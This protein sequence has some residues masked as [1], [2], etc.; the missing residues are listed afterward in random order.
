MMVVV[1][2]WSVMDA[3]NDDDVHATWVK[4]HQV[5]NS[6]CIDLI[7]QNK[8]SVVAICFLQTATAVHARIRNGTFGVFRLLASHMWHEH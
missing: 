4:R 2:I 8:Y 1:R 5:F 6:Q 7:L 3:A